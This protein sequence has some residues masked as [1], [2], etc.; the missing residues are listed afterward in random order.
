MGLIRELSTL[1]H[2]VKCKLHGPRFLF[3]EVISYLGVA[4]VCKEKL[5]FVDR[6]LEGETGL[7]ET[8]EDYLQIVERGL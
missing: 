1:P 6:L 4:M 3:R 7:L 2:N 8:N 5:Q